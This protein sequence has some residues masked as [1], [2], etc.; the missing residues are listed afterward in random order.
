MTKTP[1]ETSFPGERA[2]ANR[3]RVLVI[4]PG[5]A[6]PGGVTTFIRILMSSRLVEEKYELICLDTTRAA[7]DVPSAGRFSLRNLSYLLTQI[8]RLVLIAARQRP[9][10]M[11]IAVTSGWSFWKGG[12]FLL[13]GKAFRIRSVAHLH[14]GSMRDY[15][16][17]CSRPIQRLIG[18]VLKQADV[19]IALSGQWQRFLLDEVRSDLCVVVIPNT[20]DTPFAAAAEQDDYPSRQSGKEVLFVGQLAQAKGVFDILRAVPLVLASHEDAV[21]LFAG[22]AH[23]TRILAE[24]E[25]YSA[26]AS[27]DNAVQF[28]GEV[29]GQAKLDIFRRAALFVL[30]SF[31]EGLPYALLEAMAVGLPVITTPVGAIPEI[32]EDG[33]NGFLIQPGDHAALAKHIIHLLDDRPLGLRM[34]LANRQLIRDHFLPDVAMTKL[35]AIYDRLRGIGDPQTLASSGD[36]EREG[37]HCSHSTPQEGSI[38]LTKDRYKEESHA[39]NL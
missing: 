3:P 18:W 5:S 39:K 9:M 33:H 21:F 19:V 6:Q 27:L 38:L 10:V 4:G 30:P 32:I 34:G 24:M 37:S 8:Y 20:V 23:E 29:T 16:W 7:G 12:A 36:E 2:A 1:A 28:L 17:K 15:Y 31:G 35:V 11:H 22:G 13:I 25:R 26:E 14:G